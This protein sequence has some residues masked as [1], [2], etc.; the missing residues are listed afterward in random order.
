MKKLKIEIKMYIAEVLLNWAF[1]IAPSSEE[2]GRKLKTSIIEYFE[3]CVRCQINVLN[4]VSSRHLK[5]G[6]EKQMFNRL[7]TIFC[8][9]IS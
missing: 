2:D 9:S 5:L 1:T 8:V 3:S 7:F 6:Y 4:M